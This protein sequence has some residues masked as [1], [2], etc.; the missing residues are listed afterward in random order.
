MSTIAVVNKN[1][2]Q[3]PVAVIIMLEWQTLAFVLFILVRRFLKSLETHASIF[4][5]P[6]Y[7][8]Y[9]MSAAVVLAF[10]FGHRSGFSF[11]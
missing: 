4:S 7:A 3:N 6:Q 10:L 9:Q 1:L 8:F 5:V 2:I 11:L